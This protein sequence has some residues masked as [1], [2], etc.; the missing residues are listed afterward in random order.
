MLKRS[1]NSVAIV[2]AWKSFFRKRASLIVVLRAEKRPRLPDFWEEFFIQSFLQIADAFR[3]AR[4]AFCADHALD[5]LDVM[6]AP[7]RKVF[8]MLE[9]RF[10]QLI[11]LIELVRMTKN[12]AHRSLAFAGIA[13]TFF[14]VARI[15]AGGRVEPAPPQQSKEG[16]AE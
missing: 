6:R 12:L 11:L 4:S 10:G 13:A 9:Q 7:Q 3:T 14:F 1:W 8:I 15:V 2:T 16:L 5:H